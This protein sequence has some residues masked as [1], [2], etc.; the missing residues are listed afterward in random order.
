MEEQNIYC[1]LFL[2]LVGLC[3]VGLVAEEPL[4]SLKTTMTIFYYYYHPSS[5]S[6]VGRLIRCYCP[7]LYNGIMFQTS[8]VG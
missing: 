4:L 6:S 2:I 7:K 5:F 8:E 3:L 1:L